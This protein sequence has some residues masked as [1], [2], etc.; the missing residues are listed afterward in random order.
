MPAS[1]SEGPDGGVEAGS[2]IIKGADG[3]DGHASAV[4]MSSVRVVAVS[5]GLEVA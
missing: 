2:Y 5:I 3:F 1:V 4:K